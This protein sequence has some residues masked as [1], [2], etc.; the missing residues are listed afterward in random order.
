MLRRALVIG[1]ASL[2]LSGTATAAAPRPMLSV[3]GRHTLKVTGRY[4]HAGERIRVRLSPAGHDPIKRTRAS[5]SGTFTVT[6]H[7]V[8]VGPCDGYSILATGSDGSR[9]ML[10]RRPPECSVR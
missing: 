8:P 5:G 1:A 2:A 6:Y 10:M 7:D 9:A 4:F 3:A